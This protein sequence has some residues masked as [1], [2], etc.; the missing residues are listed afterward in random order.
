MHFNMPLYIT[1]VFRGKRRLSVM[2]FDWN[3]V[4]KVWREVEEV[5]QKAILECMMS[6][7]LSVGCS[8]FPEFCPLFFS[9]ARCLVYGV[10]RRGR[11]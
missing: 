6:D 7:M 2:S 10:A 4:R 3:A 8:G 9:L 5:V 11:F 1:I